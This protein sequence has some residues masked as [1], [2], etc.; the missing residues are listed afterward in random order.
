[1]Q[2]S[3][4]RSQKSEVRSHQDCDNNALTQQAFLNNLDQKLWSAADRLRQQLD[5]ANYKHIVLGFIFLKYVSDSFLEQRQKLASLFADPQSE[6]YLD[7]AI[8]SEDDLKNE[9]EERDYY[10]QDN[11][12]WVP[13]AARWDNIKAVAQYNI[14][15]ELPWG[16]KFGGVA[17]LIDAAFEAIEQDNPKLKGKIQRIAGYKV[18]ADTLIGLVDLF[19]DTHFS[20]P[21]FDGKPVHLAAKDILG[22]VYEY[23]LGQF[24]LAE[25]KKGGQYFTP[26]SI[27]TLIVEMLEPYEGRIYDPA[28]GSGG[29]F[30]QTE[31][32]I[33]SHQGK[34]PHASR[35][36]NIAIYG[37]EYNPTTWQLAAMNMAIRGIEF[38]F[39]N[40]NADTFTNPQH[41]DKKMDFIMANP[42][43]NMKEWW[44]E[45][46][47]Q[48]P[49][50]Q[51]GT[52]P[53]G[54]ANFAW[55]QH[56]IYHLSPKGRMALLLANGSMSSNTNNEGEIRKNILRADLVEAM[57][58]LPSQLFTNTQIPACIWILN[59]A[60]ARKGEVLFIDARQ[61]GYMK[62]RVLRDFTPDDIAKIAQTYHSWQ[63]AD[64]YQDQAAYCYSATLDDIAKNDYVLTPGRY[65]GTAEQ[66]DDGIPFAEK[67]QQL[68]ALLNEQF[69]QSAELEVKIKANL[70]TLGF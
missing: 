44:S 49:R 12:F 37:Q 61:I 11:I 39:G 10:A 35:N 53:A 43:F 28:M 34:T 54:N 56:M 55:L 18:Q 29:F 70:S 17:N 67:M 46:L 26:K 36:K 19:S 48:D 3:E 38:D 33:E 68:T 59:K 9:L 31:R 45:S 24:A 16:A 27:V 5:A 30:V 63:K 1:M 47:A 52:P 6:L 50:W 2:K 20:Q 42:P 4:V 14:G 13:E 21:T 62:D 41:L 8:Y 57:V 40:Q 51:Y 65:V 60:K 22:H 7:P 66:E 23:F 32:F 15:D 64:G 69:K 25:G 58:A